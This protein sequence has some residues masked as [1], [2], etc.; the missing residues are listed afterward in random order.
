MTVGDITNLAYLL[1]VLGVAIFG[2]WSMAKSGFHAQFF[3]ASL[4]VYLIMVGPL[5][6]IIAAIQWWLNGWD[7]VLWVCIGAGLALAA[8]LLVY[9]IGFI[10]GYF[11]RKRR[12]LR[13]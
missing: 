6:A 12:I 5:V 4:G 2:V 10:A 13:K 3:G 9:A 11:F 8:M 7:A 1:G